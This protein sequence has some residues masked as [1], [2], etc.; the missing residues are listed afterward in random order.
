MVKE[1]VQLKTQKIPEAT[2]TRLSVYSRFLSVVE[3][4]GISS[5]S[6]GEIAEG[7]GGTPAQV[8]KDL[9][10]FGD[11]GTRGVGY[12]VPSLNKAIKEI[13][14]V[15]KPWR[16]VLVG[17]G[18]LGS[19]LAH[20]SGFRNRGF[21][22]MAAFD[23]DIRKVEMTLSGLPILP[24]GDMAAYIAEHDIQIAIITVPGPAAQ[25]IGDELAD[26]GISGILN[27]SPTTLSMP[28]RVSVRNI[29]LTVNLEVLSFIIT[30]RDFLA[31]G[32]LAE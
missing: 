4:S 17:A 27:F 24:I 3:A 14:G 25:D 28:D 23:N 22:I 5:I 7:T 19:A 2:I 20:Y 6:S 13:L 21:E 16:M 30:N 12:N 26:T 29:D 15:D 8:R 32:D 1:G 9:A 10:Y 11:F 31:G 18:N